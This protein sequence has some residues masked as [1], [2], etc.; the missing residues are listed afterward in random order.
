M[1]RLGR[2]LVPD[3]RLGVVRRQIPA[4]RI[5]V[6]HQRRSLTVAG[7]GRPSQPR[8]A[9]DRVARDTA[10]LHQRKP[11]TRLPTANILLGRLPVVSGGIFQARRNAGAALVHDPQQIKCCRQSGVSG[12]P[13]RIRRGRV[14]FVILGVPQQ[15]QAATKMALRAVRLGGTPIPKIGLREIP[16]FFRPGG[17]DVAHQGLGLCRSTIGCPAGPFQR[18]IKVGRFA[19]PACLRGPL[20]P[21]RSLRS[22]DRNARPFKVATADAELRLGQSCA[23]RSTEHWKRA[24]WLAGVVQPDGPFEGSRG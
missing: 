6:A 14:A 15:R 16:E 20:Q 22:A 11:P 24:S 7:I 18:L 3:R 21:K 1:A 19:N 13:Q 10:A 9:I 12:T 17:Q 5:D 8:L 2:A 23:C 4:A